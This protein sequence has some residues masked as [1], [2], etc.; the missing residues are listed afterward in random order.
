MLPCN[1]CAQ[2][3]IAHGAE[4]DAVCGDGDTAL[5]CACRS[6]LSELVELLVLA[7]ADVNL[8]GMHEHIYANCSFQYLRM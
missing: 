7:G 6:G 4:V 1:R 3:L 2:L 5:V 8:P